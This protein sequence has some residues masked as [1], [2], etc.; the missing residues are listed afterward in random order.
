MAVGWGGL[1]GTV[2]LAASA[3]GPVWVRAL[4]IVVAFLLA[5]FLA[6]VRTL[7]YRAA[8]AAVAWVVGW[9]LWMAIVLV[10]AAVNAFGGPAEPEFAPGT[11][12]ASLAIASASLVAA[13]V[14]G[15]IA[16][17]RYSTRRLRRRH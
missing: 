2:G 1:M 7:D 4:A 9:S 17:R 3:G 6:G 16:D 13:M 10:L 8:N 12:G 15:I 5:G 14:G 11:D